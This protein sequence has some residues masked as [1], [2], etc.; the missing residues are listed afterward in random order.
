MT[1]P[2]STA[3]SFH[4]KKGNNLIQFDFNIAALNSSLDA[5]SLQIGIALALKNVPV[6]VA[7]SMSGVAASCLALTTPCKALTT[8][9]SASRMA[10]NKS[11][12][13]F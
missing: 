2:H 10:C 13:L 12:R 6:L 1:E 8:P 4:G 7:A 5:W 11:G 9:P 3:F